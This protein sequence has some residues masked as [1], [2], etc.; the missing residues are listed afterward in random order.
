M[1]EPA[2][3]SPTFVTHAR[4]PSEA[5]A[6]FCSD[7]RRRR[8]AIQAGTPSPLPSGRSTLR[9]VNI[10]ILRELDELIKYWTRVVPVEV[11]GRERKRR[12]P[13]RTQG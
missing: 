13:G 6:E 7:L 8:A 12:V 3:S 5:I 1:T 2:G 10:A 9:L 11:P 4:T